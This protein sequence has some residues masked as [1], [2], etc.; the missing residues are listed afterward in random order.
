MA[1]SSGYPTGAKSRDDYIKDYAKAVQSDKN[2]NRWALDYPDRDKGKEV[3]GKVAGFKVYKDTEGNIFYYYASNRVDVA[4]ISEIE[5]RFGKPFQDRKDDSE[6]I[7]SESVASSSMEVDIPKGKEPV[8]SYIERLSQA[9]RSEQSAINEYTAILQQ[10]SIP[11]YIREVVSEIIE[12]EKDHMVLIA[13]IV[14]EEIV[15][16]FPNNTSELEKVPIKESVKFDNISISLEKI[17][18]DTLSG[19]YTYRVTSNVSLSD[20]S[21]VLSAIEKINENETYEVKFVDL[22]EDS[23]V[24]SVKIEAS[25][26]IELA[27]SIISTIVD[28]CD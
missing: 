27:K 16:Q 9:L 12:D 23:L 26:S 22:D 21:D 15:S 13:S 7:V 5:Q 18:I 10:P 17:S 28:M 19:K 14:S 11:S 24:V 20:E 4:D 6:N 8:C 1:I 3:I 25:L 2:I